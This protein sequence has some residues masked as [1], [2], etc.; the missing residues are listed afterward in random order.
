MRRCA[1]P[2]ELA[3]VLRRLRAGNTNLWHVEQALLLSAEHLQEQTIQIRSAYMRLH[4][5]EPKVRRPKAEQYH[6]S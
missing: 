2:P 5:T 3:G 1:R 6:V 4:G